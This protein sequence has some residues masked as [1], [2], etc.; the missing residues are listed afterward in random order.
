MDF[1]WSHLSTLGCYGRGERGRRYQGRTE[2]AHRD[3]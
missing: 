3:K 2:A 1:R